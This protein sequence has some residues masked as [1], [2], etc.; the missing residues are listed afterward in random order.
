MIYG[1]V[2]SE[3]FI[4]IDSKNCYI[5]SEDEKKLIT[6][7]GVENIAVIDT[8]DAILVTD[9]SKSQEVKDL[10]EKIK[11]KDLNRYL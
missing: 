5:Y 11:A 6:T 10:V 2:G 3:N 8:K 1:N 7:I 4:S 9:L